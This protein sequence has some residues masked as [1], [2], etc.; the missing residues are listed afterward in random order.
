MGSIARS[1]ARV[2]Q[3]LGHYHWFSVATRYVIWRLDRALYRA[4]GGRL[5]ASGPALPTLLLTTVGRTTGRPQTVP[6]YYLRDGDALVVG[7][8]NSGLQTRS[9]WP[10]NLRAN[11][12]AR[13]QVGRTID[14]YRAREASEDELGQHWPRF[15]AIW[16]AVQTYYERSGERC[17]F[18]LVPTRETDPR[19]GMDR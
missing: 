11:P 14:W 6:V 3:R 15:L 7:C 4:T 1:Y 9:S 16:P 19:I 8:V 10:W 18:V 2:L 12:V 13:V 17:T 5:T